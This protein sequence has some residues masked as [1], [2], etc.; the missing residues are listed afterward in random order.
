VTINRIKLK[1]KDRD[2]LFNKEFSKLK[3]K[4][5]LNWFEIIALFLV[6]F[7]SVLKLSFISGFNHIALSLTIAIV[8]AILITFFFSCFRKYQLKITRFDKEHIYKEITA[9]LIEQSKCED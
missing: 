9:D 4:V 8:V 6:A 2:A 5:A 7:L 3:I 1:T